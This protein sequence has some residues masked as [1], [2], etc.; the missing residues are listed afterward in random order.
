MRG[1]VYASYS[2]SGEE[3][4]RAGKSLKTNTELVKDFERKQISEEMS[5]ILN[6]ISLSGIETK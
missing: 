6:A 2:E 3:F 5:E 1:H 4:F